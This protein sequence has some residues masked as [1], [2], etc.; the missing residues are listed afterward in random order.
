[1]GL[2]CGPD[3]HAS[4][5]KKL[6]DPWPISSFLE[7]TELL[8][9]FRCQSLDLNLFITAPKDSAFLAF[10]SMGTSLEHSRTVVLNLPDTVAL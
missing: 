9:G 4:D 1:M 5:M 7:V 3:T 2:I 6:D 8:R 10:S